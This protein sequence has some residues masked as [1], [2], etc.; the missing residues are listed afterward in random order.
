MIATVSLEKTIHE[1]R[2]DWQLGDLPY[3]YDHKY[4]AHVVII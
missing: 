3:G 2:F 4:T 1:K